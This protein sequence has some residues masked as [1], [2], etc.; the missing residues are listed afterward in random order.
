MRVDEKKSLL[1]A[2]N[3]VIAVTWKDIARRENEEMVFRMNNNSAL[4]KH[5]L[6]IDSSITRTR[7]SSPAALREA[8]SVQGDHHSSS[9]AD[10]VLQGY[11]S[12]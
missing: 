9:Q 1:L 6:L 8:Q 12:S 10:V 3:K 2:E 11:F 5:R 4:R 7:C